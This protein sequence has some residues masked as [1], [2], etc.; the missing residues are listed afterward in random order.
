[1]SFAQTINFDNNSS[2]ENYSTTF[3][4]PRSHKTLWDATNSA[5][6]CLLMSALIVITPL[7]PTKAH[8]CSCKRQENVGFLRA[9]GKLP[10]N[11]LGVL[12]KTPSLGSA[13]ISAPTYSVVD[14][15][16][17]QIS[18]NNFKIIEKASTTSLPVYIE[19][20]NPTHT[21]LNS[22]HKIYYIGDKDLRTCIAT[23]EGKACAQARVDISK[24]NWI[25]QLLVAKRLED[26]TELAR[27]SGKL[28]RIRP[29]SGFVEGKQYKIESNIPGPGAVIALDQLPAG[30][31][32]S[33]PDDS[34]QFSSETTVDIVGPLSF[35]EFGKFTIRKLE[36]AKH[37][38]YDGCGF[39]LPIEAQMLGFEVP[40][41]YKAY[42]H[43][44]LYF[45][46]V[47]SPNAISKE[48]AFITWQ[49]TSI[50]PIS[51]PIP[52][53]LGRQKETVYR[54]CTNA[55]NATTNP[56]LLRVRGR[57]AFWEMSDQ[58]FLTPE[59]LVTFEET[60]GTACSRK[61]ETS[62]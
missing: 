22:E 53:N 61:W 38:M 59:I 32:I 62:Y 34:N 24:E 19:E 18:A 28:L 47:M 27:S 8:A 25:K 39:A 60:R 43:Q 50:C 42:Q 16:P 52:Y 37:A 5:L 41:R 57:I 2:S 35:E 55:P 12:Y 29:S 54:V 33:K 45:T 10:S 30:E 14:S 56:E 46:E 9:A 44:L 17:T 21:S 36:G 58:V 4:M 51:A 13:I 20:V 1:M 31:T 40:Q 48:S 3:N 11:A 7:L 6:R 49:Y 26:V 23:N 15:L